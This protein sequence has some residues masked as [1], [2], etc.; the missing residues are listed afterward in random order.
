M[1]FKLEIDFSVEVPTVDDVD[2]IFDRLDDFLEAE[3]GQIRVVDEHGSSF[4]TACSGLDADS[5]R[6]L[7]DHARE[8][9]YG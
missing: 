4:G 1:R 6:A 9:G 2:P 3:F 5:R 8:H 7:S